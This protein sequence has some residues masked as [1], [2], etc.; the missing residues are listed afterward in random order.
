MKQKNIIHTGTL[1]L[2]LMLCLILVSGC[3]NFLEIP[4]PTDK[5]A[6][7][8]AYLTDN[9]AGAV[10]T[11]ILSSAAS[12]SAYGGSNNNESIGYRTSLYIDDFQ[13]INPNSTS[14][15]A[16]LTSGVF[17]A[18]TLTAAY[19]TQWSVLYKQIYYA[20]LAIEGITAN[21]GK[22]VN[23]NQWLG[24]ALFIR[25]FSYFDLINLYGDVPLATTSNYLANNVLARSSKALVVTQMINDLKQ[26]ESLLGTTYLNGLSVVTPNRARPN[27]F[28]ASA[29]L[30]RV[31]LYNGEWANA[32]AAAAKVINNTTAY[33]LVAP[34]L[35][36]LANSRETLWAL[37]P[38]ANTGAT[39]VRDYGL[40]NAGMPAQ[41]P[42]SANMA[43][44]SMTP[45][46]ESLFNSFEANDARVT[47]WLR[48][49]ITTASPTAGRFYFPNK[50]KTNVVG[51]EFNIVLR[52]AEQYL[53]R[54]ESRA[55]LNNLSGAKTDVDAVRNRASLGGITATT[56]AEMI[57]AVLKERRTE[58][59]SE[60]GHRFYDLK[61]TGLIDA[62]MN[63][64]APLKGGTWSGFKQIW[65]IPATDVIA[66]PNLTQAPEY[67]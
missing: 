17:H 66:N 42:T 27:Q 6:A 11:G 20:N 10:I 36:F 54:A 44:F 49:T 63:V 53:I 18:N 40:Y 13:L 1:A 5:L 34:G 21:Q 25:A 64:A 16:Y 56:Q 22:L 52:L 58:L 65:P 57:N 37:A 67:N 30:A 61:R 32:E 48:L 45:I 50:Y 59:F 62:V 60:F 26:A 35:A 12:N 7:D 47:N 43:T 39:F 55:R 41:A 4:L 29:L 24:E 38:M 19:S 9:S 46:S 23:K 8:G 28:V 2:A 3:K 14:N 31:Y 33:E 15:T 51:A